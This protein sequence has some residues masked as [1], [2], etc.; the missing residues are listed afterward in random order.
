MFVAAAGDPH[1]DPVD[2]EPAVRAVS[3]PSR[4][5]LRGQLPVRSEP[6][7]RRHAALLRQRRRRNLQVKIRS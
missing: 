4:R 2:H 1:G 5:R 3:E 7:P 6:G